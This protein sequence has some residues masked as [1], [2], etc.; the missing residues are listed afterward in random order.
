MLKN[1]NHILLERY[2]TQGFLDK[3]YY[4]NNHYYQPYSS[5]DRL[6]AGLRFYL[7]F[8]SWQRGHLQA[9]DI[10]IPKV[11]SSKFFLTQNLAST[12]FRKVISHVSTPFVPILYKIVLEQQEIT[13]PPLTS[14]RERLYFN[15]EIKT[16]LC[17][18]LDELIT[19]Y[20]S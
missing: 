8:L 3:K 6:H 11:D 18:G 12:R 2:F 16:L 4:H 1:K 14:K 9:K 20:K 7:D 10:S 17:R 5:S 19:H 13:P 15:D